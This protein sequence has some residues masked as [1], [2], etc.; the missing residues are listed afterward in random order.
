MCLIKLETGILDSPGS[1]SRNLL[2]RNVFLQLSQQLEML[3]QSR[4]VEELI[5]GLP[6]D[7]R[8]LLVVVGHGLGLVGPVGQGDKV[9]DILDGLEGLLPQLHGDGPLELEEPRVQVHLLRVRVVEV[10]GHGVGRA[11]LVSHLDLVPQVVS[12]LKRAIEEFMKTFSKIRLLSFG[13]NAKLNFLSSL[14]I[15]MIFLV[16]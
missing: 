3:E 14:I 1:Q 5:A 2:L 11:D 15:I 8:E 10:D 4:G 13:E 9:V 7:Q 12:Q 16:F 6:E